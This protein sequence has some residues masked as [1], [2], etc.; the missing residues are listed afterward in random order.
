MTQPLGKVQVKGDTFLPMTIIPH[1][2]NFLAIK[3][4]EKGMEGQGSEEI[5]QTQK[6]CLGKNFRG[7]G[8]TDT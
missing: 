8:V 2:L 6:L 1:S 5:G 4:K 3:L 7:R